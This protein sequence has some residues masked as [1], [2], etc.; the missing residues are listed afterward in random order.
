MDYYTGTLEADVDGG[1]IDAEALYEIDAIWSRHR[2]RYGMRR[3]EYV[4]SIAL[5]SWIF[6]ARQQTRA[7]A[8]ALLGEAEVER[9]EELALM[10]WRE[11]A[12]QDEADDW[13]DYCHDVAAE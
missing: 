10:A 11:T 12:E 7:T 4:N 3:V 2:D 6:G 13:A 5:E 8:V 1:V 9:Q